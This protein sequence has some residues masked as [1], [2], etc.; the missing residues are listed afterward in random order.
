MV[1]KNQK[2]IFI[3]VNNPIFIYQHLLPIIK[4]LKNKANLFIITPFEKKFK[5][6]IEGIK[7]I[8][9]PIKRNPS[10][11][12]FISIILLLIIKIK[13]R[14]DLSISFTPKAGLINAFTSIGQRK[15]TYHY[16]TGQR[17]ASFK[18]TKKY[19]FK[20]IDKFII[21]C[22]Y[23]VF[24]DSKSQSEFISKELNFTKTILIGK[25]SISGVNIKSFNL[26]KSKSLKTIKNP[27]FEIPKKLQNI[28]KDSERGKLKL[29]LF[30]G[31]INKD[32]GILE[33]LNGF[34]SHNKKFKNSFLLFIGPNELN[35]KDYE[36]LKKSTNCLHIGFTYQV[37]LFLSFAYCL[38]LP[39]Y[40]E[41]F[42][43]V[44]IEAAA[45]KVP[46]IASNIPGPKDFIDHMKNG[47]L[48][49]PKSSIEI[50]KALDFYYKNEDLIKKFAINSF[51]KCKKY[52]DE[53]NVCNLLVKEL[54]AEI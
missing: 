23:K 39:S 37:N 22:S 36:Q 47:Y 35:K 27:N 20:L 19:F 31:R 14:P 3:I 6:N 10:I 11:L 26:S 42:G 18:K 12:D 2:K 48:I 43:S 24:C 7:T 13:Y 49:N 8:H 29:F 45:C 52:F 53:K 32:K 5:F 1:S 40:R 16:F 33:L 51:R 38:I 9:L 25:G 17:W 21:Y 41:G 50:E 28:L 44:I 30:V 4:I 46:I 34:K 54:L 15:K